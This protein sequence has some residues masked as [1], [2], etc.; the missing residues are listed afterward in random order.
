MDV[1][2]AFPTPFS[3][4]SGLGA[5]RLAIAHLGEL[6]VAA[7]GRGDAVLRSIQFPASAAPTPFLATNEGNQALQTLLTSGLSWLGSL[8]KGAAPAAEAG[9]Q[10][11]LPL[12]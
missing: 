2:P 1:M 8:V 10:L 11:A 5:S 4:A 6:S 12:L 3:S 9:A 7:S